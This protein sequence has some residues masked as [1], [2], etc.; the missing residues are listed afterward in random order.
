MYKLLLGFYL[1]LSSNSFCQNLNVSNGILFNGEPYLAIDPN[2]NQHLIVTWMGFK[3]GQNIIIKVSHSNNGGLSWS[4]PI[5]IPHEII[6]NTSADPSIH[7]NSNGDVFLCYIDYDNVNFSNGAIFTRKSTDNGLTW[8]GSVEVISISDCPGK[9]CIDRPWMVID[10]SGSSTDGTIYVTSMNANQPTVVSAPYN[11]YLSVS[12]DNGGS[13]GTPRFLDTTNYLAG[14]II[15]QPMPSPAIDADGTFHAIYPSYET[16]QSVFPHSYLVSSNNQG[17][18]L[19]HSSS[20]TLAMPATQNQYS[21]KAS[22]LISDPSTNGHLAQIFIADPNSD[23]GDIFFMETFDTQNWTTPIQVNQDPVGKM[24]DMTWANFNEY[25]DLAICWR[26]RRNASGTGYQ[27]ETEIYARVRFKDSINFE[28][29]LPISSQQVAHDVVLE[30]N[31]NDFM[32]VQFQGDTLYTIWGDVRTGVLNIF[33]NKLNVLDGTSSIHEVYQSQP[34]IFP[35]PTSDV[36]TIKNIEDYTSLF[37]TNSKGKFIKAI[38]TATTSVS[39]LDSG[40]YLIHFHINGK[41]FSKS[42]K[43]L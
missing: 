5:E 4:I 43:I 41:H 12:M 25:G 16:T 33:L 36:I 39:N 35:N 17:A 23:D 31:G 14:S 26:D 15:T 20:Y 27:T 13:F 21:K 19:Y 8:N 29:D 6:G 18:S 37:I 11:P 34:L 30:S 28:P 32:N 3:V 42:I 1:V 7:Y 24:Q 2:N 9:L 10:K 22:L 40:I 38:T